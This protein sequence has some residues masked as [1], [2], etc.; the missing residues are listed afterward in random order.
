MDSRDFLFFLAVT[1]QNTVALIITGCAIPPKAS[2][3]AY[4]LV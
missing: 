1:Q 2:P 4:L 3:D